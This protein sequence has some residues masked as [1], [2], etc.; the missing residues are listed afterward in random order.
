MTKRT[1]NI[2]DESFEVHDQ[3]PPDWSMEEDCIRDILSLSEHVFRVTS[4]MGRVMFVVEYFGKTV[5]LPIAQALEVSRLIA[6]DEQAR[7]A[8]VAD[9]AN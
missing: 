2:G 4:W 9:S 5:K 1:V 3:C 6:A 7:R 8:V